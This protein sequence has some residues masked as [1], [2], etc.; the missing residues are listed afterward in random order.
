MKH[1]KTLK[2]AV[3]N[4]RFATGLATGIVVMVISNIVAGRNVTRFELE[5]VSE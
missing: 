5:E 1:L 2:N 3:M 4:K